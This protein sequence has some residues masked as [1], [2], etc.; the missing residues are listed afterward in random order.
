MQSCQ[1]L[2]HCSGR[3]NARTARGCLRK[4]HN[5]LSMA[6]WAA[7]GLLIAA[8]CI[9]AGYVTVQKRGGKFSLRRLDLD[10]MPCPPARWLVGHVEMLAPNFHRFL[11]RWAN[12]LGGIYRIQI[13]GMDGVVVSEPV[14]VGRILGHDHTLRELPK[15]AII[16]QVLDQVWAVVLSSFGI[17]GRNQNDSHPS[18]RMFS[19]L[20]ILDFPVLQLWGDG[21]VHSIF[22]DLNTDTWKLVRKA[23]SSAFSS[24]STR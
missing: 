4:L 19:L 9:V 7:V 21:T 23:V 13:F 20:L 2:R 10:K 18:L 15:H 17:F 3:R 8:A 14:A 11:S 6:A 1:S 24:A 22:T 12:E 5:L 16:Y